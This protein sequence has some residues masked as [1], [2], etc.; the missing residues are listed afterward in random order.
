V[1][2]SNKTVLGVDISENAINLALLRHSADGVELVKAVSCPVPDGAIKDGN[3]E[4]FAML[5]KA[6]KTLKARNK[7]RT[8][9]AAV[10]LFTKPVL[11]EIIDMPGQFPTNIGQFVQSEVKRCVALSGKE[12]ALDFCSIN[13]AAQPGTS[14]IFVLATD[15]QKVAEI[16]KVCNSAHLN[17]EAIEPPMLAYARAFY[18]E[19]I[20][21]KFD[22]NVLMAILQDGVLT[23]GVFRKQNLDF[24]S[25]KD[26]SKET[27]Q[28][29]EL[30][31]WLGDQINAIIKF[32]DVEISDSPPQWEITVVADC[33]RLAEDAEESLKARVECGALQFKTPQNAF[34]DT[35]VGQNVG[36]DGLSA[37]AIGLAM[38]VL[39]AQ[40]I[41]LGVNLLLPE[42]AEVKSFK[43]HALVTAN[44]IAMMLLPMILAG[45]V[46]GVMTKRVNKNSAQV[47]YGELADNTYSLLREE[48][49]TDKQ[50]TTL[51]G[52][53][54]GINKIL[55]SRHTL[56][57]HD[58]LNEIRFATPKKVRITELFSKPNSRIYL[59]GLASSYEVVH[60]FVKMLN[61]SE[62]I[63]SASLIETDRDSGHQGLVSYEI[64][65]SLV[66]EKGS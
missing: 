16:A 6:I 33:G 12:T 10:S 40:G 47:K 60:L 62:Y 30:C 49:L 27:I 56:Q 51:S 48:E 19:K 15:G 17:V 9:R 58:L 45:G 43:K 18:A 65:C 20:A 38:K 64:D 8:R 39:G 14:R 42:S 4:D 55:D 21:G 66:Q 3:I 22:C 1:K 26:I 25:T 41:N 61:K 5:A 44:I 37:V 2:L 36:S 11:M 31:H 28:P 24:I 23:L 32:Y 29:D 7:I 50:I 34:Q 53:V 54:E 52:R 35:F 63:D 13:S 57:W 59:K 46:L